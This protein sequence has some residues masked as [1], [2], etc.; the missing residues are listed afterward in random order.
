MVPTGGRKTVER[1]RLKKVNTK[2][3]LFEPFLQVF[4]SQLRLTQN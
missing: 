2:I 1:G 3:L 4:P